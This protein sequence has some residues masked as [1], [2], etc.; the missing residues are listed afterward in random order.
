MDNTAT[1][2]IGQPASGPASRPHRFPFE[3]VA[4]FVS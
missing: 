2:A 1:A 3:E 4:R